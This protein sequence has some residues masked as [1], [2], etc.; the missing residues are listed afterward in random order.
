MNAPRFNP[1]QLLVQ[2]FLRDPG[3]PLAI[4]SNPLAAD[5]GA[6][7]RGADV[8]QRTLVLDFAPPARYL[9]GDGVIQGGIVATMLDFALAFVV[10]AALAPGDSAA[11]VSLNLQFERAVLQGAV[12][13]SAKLDRLGGRMAFAS[14]TVASPDGKDTLARASA[15]MAVR[16]SAAA[17]APRPT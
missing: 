3:A 11:T 1:D 5:L 16:R 12:R 13:V 10:L 7:L 2:R 15:V 17:A 6:V 14:A 4:D 9:Q 8:Q